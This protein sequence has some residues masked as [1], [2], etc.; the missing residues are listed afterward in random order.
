[1]AIVKC[2]EYAPEKVYG[3]VER[4]FELLGGVQQM[5]RKGARVLIKPNLLS[6]HPPEAGIT[7]HPEVIRALIK[8]VKKYGAGPVVGDSP[9]GSTTVAEVYQKTGIE[10]V[11][12]EEDAELVFFREF[13]KASNFFISEEFFKADVV[14]SAAKFKTHNLT[15]LTAAV[16]NMYGLIPGLYKTEY[17]KNAP[18]F[19]EFAELLAQVYEVCRPH[20]SVIDGIVSMSG[21]GPVHGEL[22]NSGMLFA[23]R[24]AASVDAVLAEIIGIAPFDILYLRHI[25]KKKLGQIELKCIK[26]VGAALEDVKIKNFSKANI[27]WVCR[28]PNRLLKILA[29]VVSIGPRVVTAKCRNCHVCLKSCPTGAIEEYKGKVRINRSKCIFCLCCNEFCP[30]RAIKVRRV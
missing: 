8:I 12:R 29:M 23:G 6:A 30:Y 25:H 3:S 27:P 26:I 14:I 15:M 10:A 2:P 11:C 18:N 21:A 19:W 1:M 4:L 22:V 28:L 24:D 16:K 20:L 17:H 7:T 13:R 5:I 9:A